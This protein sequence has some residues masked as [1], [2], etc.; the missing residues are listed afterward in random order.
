MSAAQVT[1]PRPI[2]AWHRAVLAAAAAYNLVWGTLVVLFPAL[3]FAWMG[4]EPPRYPAIFQCL[5]MV[6]GVFGIGYA[7]AALDP[8]RHWPMVLVG[9]LGKTFGPLGFLWAASRRE[10]PWSFGLTILAND[11]VWWVPFWLIL[12]QAWERAEV[13]GQRAEVRE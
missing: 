6:I 3:P 5:G 8:R 7:I 13:R 10:L 11:L 2:P 1:I 4:A 12:W 9:L